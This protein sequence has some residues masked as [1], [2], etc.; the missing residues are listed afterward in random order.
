[1]S[2]EKGFIK[3]YNCFME[4]GESKL[5]PKEWYFY[6]LLAARWNPFLGI[7]ETTITRVSELQS[8]YKDKSRPTNDR[9]NTMKQ[10]SM[11]QDK[12]VISI[13]RY[14]ELTINGKTNYDKML[15]ISFKDFVQ[16]ESIY[17]DVYS[18]TNEPIELYFMCVLQR[19]K[20]KGYS[21][22]MEQLATLFDCNIKTADSTILMMKEKKL[23]KYIQGE[24]YQG[25]DGHYSRKA[26]TY[27][28]HGLNEVDKENTTEIEPE[29]ELF[30]DDD[31]QETQNYMTIYG[32]LTLQSI[33]N[34]IKHSNWGQ[35]VTNKMGKTVSATLTEDDINIMMTCEELGIE[36]KFVKKSRNSIT[37]MA[38]TFDMTDINSWIDQY[39]K[40]KQDKIERL[41]IEEMK[42]EIQEMLKGVNNAII[43]DG[44]IITL[45]PDN[46]NNYIDIIKSNMDNVEF[47]YV[48]EHDEYK[49]KH[50]RLIFLA[51]VNGSEEFV[52]NKIWEFT[53]KRFVECVH[54]NKPITLDLVKNIRI[55]IQSKFNIKYNQVYQHN[56]H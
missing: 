27:F 35:K 26:N 43:I 19:F 8:V 22:T 29:T 50:G 51:V 6:S 20:K 28:I 21:H 23:I 25:K 33:Q 56:Y 32:E 54:G 48:D 34:K 39:V 2:Y 55:E 30:V 42:K 47:Y 12:G 38:K 49:K 11:L 46:V 41:E 31:L 10:I 44:E 16:S 18:R 1:M 4:N 45:T 15:T 14:D 52:N 37:S 5:S 9:V 40:A 3:F 13:D 53:V 7:A 24:S 17:M 36:S